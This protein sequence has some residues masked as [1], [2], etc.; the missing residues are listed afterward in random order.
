MTK[1]IHCHWENRFVLQQYGAVRKFY[2]SIFLVRFSDVLCI[3]IKMNPFFVRALKEGMLA[4]LK[5][6][7]S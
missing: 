6:Y 2:L 3:K 1:T 4:R 5:R 7:L